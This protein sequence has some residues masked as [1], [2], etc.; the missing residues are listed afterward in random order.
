MGESLCE[1]PLPRGA[2][3]P[4]DSDKLPNTTNACIRARWE[5]LQLSRALGVNISDYQNMIAEL[6]RLGWTITY[7]RP[8]EP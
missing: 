4:L 8:K 6:E 3:W 7:S 1:Q 2:L 5:F